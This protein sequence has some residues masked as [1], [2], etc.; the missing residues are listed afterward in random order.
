MAT[1][2]GPPLHASARVAIV[3]SQLDDIAVAVESHALSLG[4]LLE[5]LMSLVERHHEEATTTPRACAS[6]AAAV[7]IELTYDHETMLRFREPLI[8]VC[9]FHDRL[10]QRI[11]H[12]RAALTPLPAEP[13]SPSQLA[14]E[15]LRL[16]PFDEE[17]LVNARLAGVEDS[18]EEDA[19]P[20]LEIF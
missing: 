5:S 4:M 16:F 1:E 17:R 19:A 10:R 12:V 11:E 3:Q 6:V 9:Q 8:M 7:A 18:P 13:P 14:G 2:E 20:D 15:V